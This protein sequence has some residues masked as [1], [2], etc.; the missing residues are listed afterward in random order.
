MKLEARGQVFVRGIEGH[1][2]ESH[3]RGRGCALM[4][5]PMLELDSQLVVPGFRWWSSSDGLVNSTVKKS[6]F[7]VIGFR[8]SGLEANRSRARLK[9][10]GSIAAC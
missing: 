3:V 9:V 1:G 6:E 7:F 4:R 10:M 8:L 2:I 5:S